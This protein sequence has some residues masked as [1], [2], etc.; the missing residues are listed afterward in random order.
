MTSDPY[1]ALWEIEAAYAAGIVKGYPTA[2]LSHRPG[3]A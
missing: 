3:D 1:W 2:L